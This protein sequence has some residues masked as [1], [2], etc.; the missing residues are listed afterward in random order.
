LSP[1]VTLEYKQGIRDK[2]LEAAENLFSKKGYYDTS[3]DEI[4]KES[5]L[6]KGAIYGYFDSK[7][8]LFAAL[9]DRDLSSSLAK[10][11]ESFSQ[12]DS[13]SV[14]LEKAA[15]IAFSV[16]VG[17]SRQA[18]RMNLE[19][20]VAAPR[21]KSLMHRQDDRYDIVHRLIEE[22]VEEGIR[23]G[24]FRRDIDIDVTASILEAVVD[25][26]ALHWA[27]TSHDLNW[28]KL[29]EQVR[30]VILKGLLSRR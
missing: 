15:H 18:C 12:D 6:S 7:E 8:E 13:A 10:I 21:M 14:K 1:K 3:M 4:V 26:L 25:G 20:G 5:G 11:K 2:I 28:K 22:I 23:T 29:E 24:E 30:L 9:Q 19:F 16:L 27:T 17:K